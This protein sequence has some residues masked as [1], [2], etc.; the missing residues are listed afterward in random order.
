MIYKS[1]TLWCTYIMIY[2]CTKCYLIRRDNLLIISMKAL[3][4]TA[5]LLLY[6]LQIY[7]IAYSA[8]A[9]LSVRESLLYM[10]VAWKYSRLLHIAT[11]VSET[12]NFWFYVVRH[13]IMSILSSIKFGHSS[14]KLNVGKAGQHN[15][16]LV[17][18]FP[19]VLRKLNQK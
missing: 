3:R 11:N 18:I 13:V 8:M 5:I 15:G 2:I 17:V 16:L 9:C 7:K 10:A 1:L 4:T 14:S 12:S 19:F 6:I